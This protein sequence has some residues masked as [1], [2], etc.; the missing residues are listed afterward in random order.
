[1][2]PHLPINIRLKGQSHRVTKCKK[3]IEGNQV[4]SMSLLQPLSSAHPLAKF[5]VEC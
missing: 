5:N 2:S 4:A 3:I 1:M